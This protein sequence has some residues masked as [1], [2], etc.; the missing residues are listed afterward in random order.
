[1]A[2]SMM[3]SVLKKVNLGY[4]EEKFQ[5]EK[6]TPDL[7]CKLSVQEL[8]SLGLTSRR[9]MMALRIECATFG[10]EAP[11]K[12]KATCGAPSFSIPKCVLENLL[13]EGFTIKEISTILFVSESNIYRRMSLFGL[14]K[15]DFTDISDLELD[16][17][18]KNI[19]EDFPYCGES[20]IKQFVIEK[21]IIV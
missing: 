11:R 8:E 9:D 21:G 10:G 18:I 15:S 4:L 2:V 19:T 5:Q 13:G 17:H 1:M 3:S 16:Q 7:V 20:L 12:V 6:I 14:G